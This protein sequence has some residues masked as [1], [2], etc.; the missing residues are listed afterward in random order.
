MESR[1]HQQPQDMWVCIWWV[2]VQHYSRPGY[3]AIS[4][5]RVTT[6]AAEQHVYHR[7]W[8]FPRLVYPGTSEFERQQFAD[9]FRIIKGAEQHLDV[10]VLRSQSIRHVAFRK[11]AVRFRRP[12]VAKGCQRRVCQLSV[13]IASDKPS[14]STYTVRSKR[15]G[16][17]TDTQLYDCSRRLP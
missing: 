11:N 5:R 8:H 17:C 1:R 7:S 10:Q 12:P 3:P 9:V 6:D 13:R 14:S 16:F 2:R 4:S 15:L